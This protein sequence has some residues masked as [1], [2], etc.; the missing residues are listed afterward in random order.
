M[1]RDITI[2][3]Y[4]PAA[5]VIHALDPRVKLMGTLILF[6]VLFGTNN[7]IGYLLTALLLTV[8][9]FISGVPLRYFFRGLRG[10]LFLLMFSG[11]FSIFST[12]G[13]HMLFQWGVLRI[14]AEGILRAAAIVLRIL[15]LLAGSSFLTYTTKPGDIADG[16]EKALSPLRRLRVPVGDIAMIMSIALRFIPILM[17]ELDK[18]HL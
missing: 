12:A 8:L 6:V 10:V 5:S 3:Q 18:I 9:F 7:F 14:S 11:L 2:G 17:E 1:M 4:Y 13:S 16:L 15:L